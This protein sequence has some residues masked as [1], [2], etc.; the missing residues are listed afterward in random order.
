M[1]T[2]GVLP[3]GSPYPF[4]LEHYF[5][6]ASDLGPFRI[7]GNGSA[8][9]IDTDEADLEAAGGGGL[10]T[11]TANA[12]DNRSAGVG[13]E[14]AVIP[15]LNGPLSLVARFRTLTA[16]NRKALFVGF[17]SESV[18]AVIGNLIL[19]VAANVVTPVEAQFA[20]VFREDDFRDADLHDFWLPAW[21]GGSGAAMPLTKGAGL[22]KLK[23]DWAESQFYDVGVSVSRSGY[24]T[25]SVNGVELMNAEGAV[26]PTK[27]LLAHVLVTNRAGAASVLQVNHMRVEGV[28]GG[29]PA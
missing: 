18:Q 15:A 27:P 4:C 29:I 3:I 2:A 24:V 8:A 17:S 6:R 16:A 22:G 13:M 11:F 26:D 19:T 23:H 28:R 21:R 7:L 25:A 20:G 14:G 9:A 5:F 1:T 12:A 10:V